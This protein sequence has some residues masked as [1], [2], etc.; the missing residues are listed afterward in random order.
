[1]DSFFDDEIRKMGKKF[2]L[3]L[4]LGKYYKIKQDLMNILSYKRWLI[5]LLKYQ[6]LMTVNVYQNLG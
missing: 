3:F 4:F 5:K 6:E 1:M 2:H